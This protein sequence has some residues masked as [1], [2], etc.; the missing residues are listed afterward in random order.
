VKTSKRTLPSRYFS[1]YPDSV[2]DTF[3]SQIDSWET[4]AVIDALHAPGRSSDSVPHTIVYHILSNPALLRN[5][6]LLAAVKSPIISGFRIPAPVPSGLILM[7]ADSRSEVH[8]LVTH[9]RDSF[10]PIEDPAQS[11]VALV[12]ALLRRLAGRSINKTSSAP[13]WDTTLLAPQLWSVLPGV[14]QMFTASSIRERFVS[15]SAEVNLKRIVIG[16]LASTN[17]EH[18]LS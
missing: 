5:P 4:A 2:L 6:S 8:S 12:N 9:L 15:K 18:E 11:S 10:Q 3:F 17:S 13:L 14:L 1:D 16:N 7:L